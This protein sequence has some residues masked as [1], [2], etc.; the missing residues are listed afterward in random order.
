MRSYVGAR[1]VVTGG[2]VLVVVGT[3]L[4]VLLQLLFLGGFSGEEALVHLVAVLSAAS[5]ALVALG[6]SL[7]GAGIVMRALEQSGVLGPRRGRPDE[8]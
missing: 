3:L 7:V 6:A 2:V 1:S 8:G 4:P 5:T